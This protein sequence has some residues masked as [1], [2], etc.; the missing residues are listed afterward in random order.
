MNILVTGANGFLGQHLTLYLSQGQHWSVT[1]TG[2]HH[3]R[4][5]QTGSFSY[6][7]TDLTEQPAVE[8]L[9]K[10]IQPSWIIHTAAMSKPDACAADPENCLQHNVAATRY[11]LEAAAATGRQVHVLYVSSDF[12]FG[13]GGPH[14][15]DS[16]PQPLNFYGQSKWQAEQLVMQSGLPCTIVRP[17]FIYGKVW[18][19]MRPGFIQWVQQS[20]SAGK[21]IK[22]VNDQQRTPTYVTDICRGIEQVLQLDKTGVYHLAGD[23]IC[24]PYAVALATAHTLGLDATLIEA[25]TAETF[26][27]PVQRA[28]SSG[29]KIEKARNELG[30]NPV[31]LKDGIELSFNYS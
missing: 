22:V 27:E 13:E 25:V 20:L 17:A 30:Y 16:Q 8:Q 15:E 7:S 18:E 10:Q 24:S 5:P 23:E 29:L 2:L 12:I 3:C 21:K 1:A 14:T 26:P 28:K 31:C 9:I 4:I 6:I 11:L 19:G